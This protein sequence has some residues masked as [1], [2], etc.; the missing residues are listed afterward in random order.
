MR[1]L[2]PAHRFLKDRYI[3]WT[4]LIPIRIKNVM[5]NCAYLLFRNIIFYIFVNVLVVY[6]RIANVQDA[7]G[8]V[9]LTKEVGESK[10]SGQDVDG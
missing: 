10:E 3:L 9:H 4:W 1:T 8:L 7:V 6:L 5:Y 2:I